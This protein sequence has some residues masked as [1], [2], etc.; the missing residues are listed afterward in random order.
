MLSALE[1]A[2]VLVPITGS[3]L[4]ADR[5]FPW[6]GDGC[7]QRFPRRA[8]GITDIHRRCISA[9]CRLDAGFTI[10]GKRDVFPPCHAIESPD[11]QFP[12]SRKR[13]LLESSASQIVVSSQ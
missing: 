10:V 3:D 7:I 9:G 8:L 11:L 12:H 13:F 4:P 2:V 5:R 6:R 1:A